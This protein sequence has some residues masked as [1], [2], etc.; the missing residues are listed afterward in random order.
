MIGRIVPHIVPELKLLF[1]KMLPLALLLCWIFI[2]WTD[3][4]Y[5]IRNDLKLLLYGFLFTLAGMY[6]CRIT[7]YVIKR[8]IT[9][10]HQVIPDFYYDENNNSKAA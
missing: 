10:I 5:Q 9:N 6:L 2:L 4:Q 7:A 8:I 3:A 1:M